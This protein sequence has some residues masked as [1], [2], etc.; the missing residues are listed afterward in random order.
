MRKK[1]FC[2]LHSSLHNNKGSSGGVLK[3]SDIVG[4]QKSGL[5]WVWVEFGLG[6]GWVWAG[7][8]LGLRWV[9]VGLGLDQ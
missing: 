6:L 7:F 9:W 5:G 8:G 1:V 3:S 2:Q 4:Q